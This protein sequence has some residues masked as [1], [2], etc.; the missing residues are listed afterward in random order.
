MDKENANYKGTVDA[1]TARYAK[2][3]APMLIPIMDDKQKMQGYISLLSEK[4]YEF[5]T[6]KPKVIDMPARYQPDYNTLRENTI[7]VAASGC[8]DLMMKYFE[9]EKLT[10]AEIIKGVR[11]GIANGQ[12]IGIYAGSAVQ[13][14][15]VIKLL[16]QIIRLMPSPCESKVKATDGAGKEIEVKCDENGPLAMQVFKTIA[17]QF[18]KL[19]L[20]KVYRGTVKGGASVLNTANDK[21]ERINQVVTL[22]GKKQESADAIF[23][24]DICAI[25]KLTNTSTGDSLADDKNKIT[26][27]PIPFPQPNISYAIKAAKQGEEEKVFAALYRLNEEDPSFKVEKNAETGEILVSG[28]GDIALNIICRKI[29]NRSNVEAVLSPPKVAYRETIRKKVD[30][31]EGKHKKQTGGAGQYG[32]VKIRFEPYPD[33]D[34]IF[35]QECVG[36]SVPKSFHPAVEKGLRECIQEGVLAGYPV[37]NLKAVLFD[38]SYHDVDSKEI[39]FVSA[40]HLAFK[41]GIPK[42]SPVLLEP[43]MKLRIKVPESYY[44]SISGD[45]N[46]KRRGNIM[47]QDNEGGKL[48]IH[49]EAPYAEVLTYSTDLRSMTQSRGTFTMEQVRYQEVPNDV[50]QKVIKARQAESAK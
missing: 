19:S 17:D 49:A 2:K 36:G 20:A 39:A 45:M 23:A 40:A 27:L 28:L 26:L 46:S 18:G 11:A 47:G 12:T 9:G 21:Y 50:A 8:D 30:L 13:N 29:K 37:I 41:D 3:V 7:E 1:I 44:G 15:G 34:F 22:K 24:G 38:G 14:R 31:A 35:E 16:Y 25:P 42:A 32:H 4:S 5:C 43:V 48:I 10:H 33:G 6:D